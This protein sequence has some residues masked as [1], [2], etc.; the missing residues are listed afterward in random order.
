MPSPSDLLVVGSPGDERIERLQKAR[1][2]RGERPARVLAWTD[3]ALRPGAIAAAVRPSTVVRLDSPGKSFEAERALVAAGADEPED[4]RDLAGRAGAISR[5]AALALA[6]ERGRLRF[7]RQ[8]YRGFRATAARVAAAVQGAGGRL[9][10]DAAD[11][12]CMF[13]K[14]ACDARL[15]AAG[16]PVAGGQ[17]IGQVGG[18]EHLRARLGGLGLT[19]AFVKL[20]HGSSGAGVLALSLGPRGARAFTTVERVVGADGAAL[21]STRAIR[22]ETD[23]RALAAIVDALSREGV[24]AEPWLPKATL[25]NRPL[26][27]R[28]LTLAGAARHT[29]VRLGRTVITNLQA[30]GTRGDLAALAEKL[31][32]GAVVGARGA[33]VAASRAFPRSLL[34]GVDVLLD[35][36]GRPTVL[37]VNAFGDLLRDVLDRGDD[38]YDAWL[39]LVLGSAPA[40]GAAPRPAGREEAACST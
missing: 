39:R 15:H 36:R 5:T 29:V 18:W 31:G 28:V 3:A 8:W 10:F 25:A 16:V 26:D 13:D 33:A 24:H 23:E 6:P 2:R 1:A 27:L 7:S 22:L 17:T 34:A 12:A 32:E 20:A 37:E 19:R 11:V 30:G 40:A 9:T 21:Y 38:P 14:R 4:D 35:P